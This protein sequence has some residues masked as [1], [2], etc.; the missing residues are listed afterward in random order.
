MPKRILIVD[1]EPESAE[2]IRYR[3]ADDRYEFEYAA[4]GLEAMNKV[5]LFRPD[6]VVLDVLL[7][8]LDG[9][10]LCQSLNRQ[11]GTLRVPVILISALDTT[12]TRVAGLAAGA[13][14][15][16]AKPVDFTQLKLLVEA[17]LPTTAGGELATDDLECVRG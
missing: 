9:L 7:P 1:D 6:L 2:L 14:A 11:P 10:T 12:A 15:F 4:R 13:R 17:L 3:L 16:L 5:N 8:D